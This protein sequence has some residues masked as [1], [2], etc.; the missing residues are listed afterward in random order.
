MNKDAKPGANASTSGSAAATGK[1]AVHV[2]VGIK[3]ENQS[4]FNFVSC[5]H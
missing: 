4:L 2:K 5:G 3:F 1:K